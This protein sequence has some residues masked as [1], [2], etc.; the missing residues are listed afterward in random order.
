MDKDQKYIGQIQWFG[1]ADGAKY[2]FADFKGDINSSVFFHKNTIAAEQQD[3]LSEFTKSKFITAKVRKSFKNNDKLEA[4]GVSLL[5]NETDWDFL[6]NAYV[7]RSDDVVHDDSLYI[8]LFDIL[9]RREAQQL[10]KYLIN[11]VKNNYELNI[12]TIIQLENQ[13]GA[14]LFSKDEFRNWM[15]ENIELTEIID[16]DKIKSLDS[17]FRF[18]YQKCLDD[19]KNSILDRII[20]NFANIADIKEIVFDSWVSDELKLS[21]AK[22]LLGFDDGAHI[23]KLNLKEIQKLL[24]ILNKENYENLIEKAILLASPVAKIE[25]WLNDDIQEID[26]EWLKNVKNLDSENQVKFIKKLFNYIHLNKIQMNLDEILQIDVTDYSSKVVLELLRLLNQR[27]RINQYQL[28]YN[29]LEILS[30]P[31]LFKKADDVLQLQHY[32]NECNGR[33]SEQSEKFNNEVDY[34]VYKPTNPHSN[35]EFIGWGNVVGDRIYSYF[36]SDSLAYIQN[37]KP[38]QVNIRDRVFKTQN[39]KSRQIKICDGTLAKKLSDGGAH[40]WW[41]DNRVCFQHARI[42]NPNKI[43]IDYNLLDFLAILQMPIY[44]DEIATLY[45]VINHVNRFLEHMNC[46]S[47]GHLLKPKGKSLYAFYRVTR[48]DCRNPECEKPDL[49]VYISHCS[50]ARCVGVVDSRTSAKCSNGWVICNSCF[51]CCSKEHL[52]RRNVNL[53][54]AGVST[55][56]D[57]VDNDDILGH[58][59]HLILCPSCSNPFHVRSFADF[60]SERESVLVDFE[61]LASLPIP[62]DK[63]L[64]G[65]NGTNKAGNRWFVVYKRHLDKDHFLSMLEYWQSIG[66]NIPDLEKSRDRLNYLVVEPKLQNKNKISNLQC[67]HCGYKYKSEIDESRDKAI[68]YWHQI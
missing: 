13:F 33:V 3:S 9:E 27:V 17:L 16:I 54:I 66:F 12:S 10:T 35:S 42:P 28:R 2:G 53:R 67:Q 58:C 41:C 20:Y 40:F 26:N 57:I 15:L 7:S 56:N 18:H 6:F 11:H 21:A 24:H 43:W 37:L 51:A 64:V 45:G 44:D 4:Y 34:S 50:N 19:F 1:T 22:A 68:D 25:L 32:F 5:E 38:M 61:R 46:I 23:T 30:D 48:F 31:S 36:K 47:C 59:G 65:K 49:D 60:Q 14:K 52:Q 29:L 62:A 63:K 8:E 55:S 39:S